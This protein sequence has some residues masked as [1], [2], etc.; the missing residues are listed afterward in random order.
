MHHPTIYLRRRVKYTRWHSKIIGQ[1]VVGLTKYWKDTVGFI[2]R[3]R[4]QTLRYF[5]LE[6]PAK[7]CNLIHV[8]QHLENNLRTDVV[9]EVPHQCKFLFSEGFGRVPSE[10]IFFKNTGA[11]GVIMGLEVTDALVVNLH[12][13]SLNRGIV[14]QVFGHYTHTRTNLQDLFN[15]V[16]GNDI[17]NAFCNAFV[18]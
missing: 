16:K 4:A 9:R 15:T 13:P 6:H 14:Q 8:V 17:G 10:E 11:Q 1:I 12:D 2:S 18:L 7:K 3:W 5:L